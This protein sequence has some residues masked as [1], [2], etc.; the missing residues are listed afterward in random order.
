MLRSEQEQTEQKSFPVRY[1][2]TNGL[3]SYR[4]IDT[5]VWV[6]EVVCK[7][8]SLGSAHMIAKALNEAE[9]YVYPSTY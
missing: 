6:G 4:V 7:T 8:G 5:C 3:F 1:M 9:G 2:V